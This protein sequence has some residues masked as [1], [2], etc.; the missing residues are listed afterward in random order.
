M[1]GGNSETAEIDQIL[2]RSRS[3]GGVK[4]GDCIAAEVVGV[5]DDTVEAATYVDR[6]VTATADNCIVIIPAGERIITAAAVEQIIAIATI[7]RV[8]AGPTKQL[9]VL[10]IAVD[11]VIQLITGTGYRCAIEVKVLDSDAEQ[12]ADIRFDPVRTVRAGR[13]FIDDIAGIIDVV[14]VVTGAA[15]HCVCT[16]TAI[17]CVIA[18]PADQRIVISATVECIVA[19]EPAQRIGQVT[20]GDNVGKRV[21]GADER[22]CIGAGVGEI[23]DV[24]HELD[25]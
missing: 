10:I 5:I 6:I 20:A 19:I 2:S 7:E 23:L 25:R 24:G 4:A 9:V 8:I 21:T 22:I 15:A 16:G 13:A 11:D 17:E 18:E 14:H 1:A 12:V 3:S